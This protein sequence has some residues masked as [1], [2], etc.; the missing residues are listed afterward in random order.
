M[1]QIM[2]DLETTGQRAGCAIL[3]IGAVQFDHKERKLGPEFYRVVSLRSCQEL[4]LFVEESTMKWWSEQSKEAQ[5]VLTQSVDGGRG[6]LELKEALLEFNKYLSQWGVDNLKVW[7]NGS[8]FDNAILYACYAACGLEP[9]WRFWNSRC[10]RTL[11]SIIPGA[12]LQRLG[13]YHNALD[14]AKS[15]AAH[16]IA[17]LG[18]LNTPF[19]TPTKLVSKGQLPKPKKNAKKA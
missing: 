13:V 12:K 7:G 10:Y 19:G 3:S 2:L 4:G 1:T 6:T 5:T 15:Q 9:G 14:D 18:E 16:A 17:L 8:D 11:K